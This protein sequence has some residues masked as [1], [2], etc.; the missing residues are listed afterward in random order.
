MAA[1]V[2]LPGMDGTGEQFAELCRHLDARLRAVVVAYP[3][4]E[5]LSY[6]ALESFVRGRLPTDQPYIIVAESFSG[7]IAVSVAAS[8][9]RGLLG[10][11]L[12][13]SFVRNPHPW[14][15]VCRPIVRCLPFRSLPVSV[16]SG[17]LLGRFSSPPLRKMLAHAL[18]VVSPDTFRTRIRALLEVDVSGCLSQMKVP[19]L[20]LRATE[21]RVVPKS[22]SA[23]I[24]ELLPSAR[25]VDVVA[26][27]FLLQAVPAAAARH[28]ERFAAE[29]ALEG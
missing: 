9:P 10:L 6:E 3:C 18:A 17:A 1:V 16:M 29:V 26:P 11:I 20:Y 19:L 5:P 14:L 8:A 21:D 7:P 2:L 13:C 28:I 24:L 12:S 22:A 4:D 23:L 15:R 25:I 27:H